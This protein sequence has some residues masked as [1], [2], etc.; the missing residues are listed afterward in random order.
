M[1]LLKFWVR[2][3]PLRPP[4]TLPPW[5]E[6]GKEGLAE[7]WAGLMYRGLG[8]AEK[9]LNKEIV[10]SAPPAGKGVGIK[11]ECAVK[12]TDGFLTSVSR[13]PIRG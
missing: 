3:S 4:L 9:G 8:N 1:P 2:R 10:L 12:S 11:P 7:A 6:V 5:A 13:I